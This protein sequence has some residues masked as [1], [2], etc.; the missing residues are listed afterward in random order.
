M[1][2]ALTDALNAPSGRLAEIALKKLSRGSSTNELPDEM[3]KRLD[4]LVNAP[5][6]AGKLARIRLASEVSY[7]FERAPAWTKSSILPLFDWTSADAADAWQSRK[8][9]NYIGSPE[10]FGL[11]KKPFLEMFGRAG[12]PSEDLRTFAEWL[13]V[14][15][16]ANIVHKD[17]L[18]PLTA[19]ESRAALRRA[20][21][22]ALS[23][24]GHRL[25]T[26]MGSAKPEEK[27]QNW[28]EIVCPVFQAIW[29]LDV[30]LQS[31]ATTFKLVQILLA[32]GEAFPEAA[33]VIIPFIRPDD[34]R[35]YSAIFSIAE[36]P[37]SLYASSPA[38]M[39]D[40]VAAVVGDASP[41]SVFALGKALGRIRALEPSLASTRKFQK[42]LTYASG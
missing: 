1:R 19:H 24:V 16:I 2:D 15:L 35:S 7:L 12:V 33:D 9:S 31:H 14:I 22:D 5:G 23:S 36:A 10:L 29:P 25:A 20:G 13:A 28:R 3:R 8:Y 32:T 6:T 34:R 37:E 42:L 17:D 4:R 39:L 26:E 21:V 40:L 30:D 41:G 18:Y 27:I 11:T 38:K